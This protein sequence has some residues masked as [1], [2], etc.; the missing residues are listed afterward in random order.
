MASQKSIVTEGQSIYRHSL[1][2]GSNYAY[3]ST[4]KSIYIRALDYEMWDVIKEGPYI[5]TSPSIITREKISKP[6]VKWIRAEMK[7]VQI[8]FKVINIFHCA[9]THIK[10]NKVLDCTTTKK[11]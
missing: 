11:I 5:P 6:K 1:L 3:W 9:F 10:F 8:N 4:R 2:D 7:K